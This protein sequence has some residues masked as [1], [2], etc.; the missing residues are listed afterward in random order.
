M[1]SV[2]C[3]RHSSRR[4]FFEFRV[5][6]VELDAAA[7]SKSLVSAIR[8]TDTGE[9]PSPVMP[10]ALHAPGG[11]FF[12]FFFQCKHSAHLPQGM[13]LLGRPRVLAG[14]LRD[15]PGGGVSVFMVQM[16]LQHKKNG[17]GGGGG[18]EEGEAG[19]GWRGRE[20]GGGTSANA[21]TITTQEG[22]RRRTQKGVGLVVG[23]KCVI[24]VSK[25]MLFGKMNSQRECV[26]TMMANPTTPRLCFSEIWF[27][28]L[29]K[30]S[31]NPY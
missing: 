21:T 28:D 7:R 24:R 8:L 11:H 2:D 16:S 5:A 10:L 14:G 20:R 9:L 26:P 31:G 25:K 6:G 13:V 1:N 22:E 18:D 12:F 15:G 30:I 29:L 17:G 23:K 3:T 4:L 19:Q 27:P